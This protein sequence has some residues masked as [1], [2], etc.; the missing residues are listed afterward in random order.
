MTLMEI[1]I[2]LAVIAA[3]SSLG[4]SMIR[5]VTEADL[6]EQATEVV[7]VM[8]TAYALAAQTGKHHRVVF[9]LEKQ[10]FHIE[11]CEDGIK[12]RKAEEEEIPDK[13]KLVELME[14][15]PTS[16]QVPEVLK[17]ASPA[18]AFEQA[19][20]LEGVQIGAARCKLYEGRTG[21][22]EGRGAVRQVRTDLGVEI[23]R[24]HVQHLEDEAED[25]P[26]SI[27]FFPLGYAEKAVIE[28][29]NEAGEQYTL[30]VHRLTG[31][32]ELKKGEFDAEDHMRRD[33]LGEEEEER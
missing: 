33:A 7:A 5:R 9:D 15:E 29:V 23:R 20:A 32:I 26:V 6:R 17:A 12:L 22:A 11:V 1:M 18:E 31:Q 4:I 14:R 24:I 2:V 8:R 30:L 13:E 10:G 3:V 27:N 16:D 21:D 28:I 19:A 25:G